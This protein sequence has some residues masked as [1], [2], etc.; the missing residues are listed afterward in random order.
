MLSILMRAGSF[1]A[2]I[3]LGYLLR[4]AGFFKAEDFDTLAKIS[5]RIT[6]PCA[7][8]TS[9]AGKEID[10]ALLS[11]PLMALA[12]GAVYIAIGFMMNRGND[13]EI[14][15]FDMLNLAGYN[16][17]TF[18][19]PFA[20]SFLGAMGVVAV[21]IFDT[22]NAVICLGGAYSLASMVKDGSGFS[23]RRLARAL[24]TSVPFV[25]YILMLSMNLLSLPVPAFVRSVAEVGSG[26]NAFVAMLMIG[27]GFRL[28][29]NR[30]QLGH[31]A[32]IIGIRY[33]LAT[34]FALC[35][36]FL[37]PFALEIRQALVILAFAP[38][39]SAVP[40]FTREMKSDA[41]L[42]SAINSIA[43]VISITVIVSLLLIML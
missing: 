41:G 3:A 32:R 7:I 36:Y 30:S 26:A 20:Q 8:I 5:I 17:G 33:A 16:I 22:G 23:L 31:I 43:M 40:A 18:V 24:G 27:V 39:G 28:E 29:A 13:R 14:R 2:I 19:I 4:K 11:L 12:C 42:S 6:L 21:S 38:I 34:V 1:I 37:T 15:A 35:F 10:M 9:F 25:T